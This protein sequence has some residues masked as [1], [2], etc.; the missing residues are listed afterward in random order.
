M[1][2]EIWLS[3]SALRTVQWVSHT[4][5]MITSLKIIN[6]YFNKFRMALASQKKEV[7]ISNSRSD[8]Q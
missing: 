8:D 6:G 2:I 3:F 7:I 4:T 1:A 5:E